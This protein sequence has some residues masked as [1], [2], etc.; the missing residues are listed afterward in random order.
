LSTL[1]L[2]PD[3]SVMLVQGGVFLSAI[4]AVNKLYLEPFKR[5]KQVQKDNTEGVFHLVL[6]KERERAQIAED[7]KKQIKLVEDQV[8]R[9]LQENHAQTTEEMAQK[10][11]ELQEKIKEEH[12]LF[13]QE[14][15]N[16][17]EQECSHLE[18]KLQKTASDLIANLLKG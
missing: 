2:A 6:E 12:L 1:N 17:Y 14:I 16:N 3:I 15:K 4:Y 10:Q 11:A 8:H 13:K 7:I 5:Y 18:S 9:Q